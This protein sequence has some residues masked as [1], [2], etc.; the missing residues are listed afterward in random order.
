MGTSRQLDFIY[1]VG[2]RKLLILLILISPNVFSIENCK[3][4]DNTKAEDVEKFKPNL[5]ELEAINIA[6]RT[7]RRKKISI[8]AEWCRDISLV[9]N[10]SNITWKVYYGGD[11][12]D[13]CFFV[14][15]NDR[16]KKSYIDYCG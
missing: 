13:A 16:T 5:S 10:E 3:F 6:D 9:K 14:V 15:I 12:L 4:K 8:P 1:G 7:A 2:V 11:K